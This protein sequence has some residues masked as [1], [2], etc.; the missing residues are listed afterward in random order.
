MAQV[1]D[2][3]EGRLELAV[4]A[5]YRNWSS[6]FKEKFDLSTGTAHISLE[7][8]SFL[9]QGD[10][11][12]T[13]YLYDLIMNLQKLGSGFEFNELSKEKKMLVIDRYLFLLDQI[14]F[15][16][17]RRLGWLESYPGEECTLVE[18]VSQFDK[19]APNFRAQAPVLSPSHPGYRQYSALTTF[20]KEVFVRKMIPKV[21]EELPDYSTTL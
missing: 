20:D 5:G 6:K 8:L 18:L 14:R 17:M 11:K 15:E 4:K 12:G 9:A 13:F 10:E 19:L 2:L 16:C 7:T 21:L 1:I 3:E